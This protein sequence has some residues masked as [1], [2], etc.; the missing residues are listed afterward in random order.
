M[1]VHLVGDGSFESAA[2]SIHIGLINNM[3]DAALKATERQFL[4]L[5]NAAADGVVVNVSLYAL[6]EVPRSESAKGHIDRF[7]SGIDNLWDSRLDGLIVT[8]T[9]PRAENLRDEPYWG[10]LAKVVDWAAR[11]THSTV[12]S[13]L[14][15]HAAVLHMDNIPRI[16]SKH[17]H[18]G[19][20]ECEKLS[21]HPLIDGT[22][23][24]FKIPHSRWN[25]LSEEALTASG[26]EVLTRAE[27]VGV[28]TFIK[29]GKNL[30]VFFNGHPEYASNTLLLEYKRD[31]IRFLKSETDTYPLLPLN[32]FAPNIVATLTALEE[33]AKANPSEKWVAD[34]TAILEEIRIE[35]SWHATAT[36][37]YQNWLRFISVQKRQSESSFAPMESHDRKSQQD[38]PISS[39]AATTVADSRHALPSKL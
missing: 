12:W 33:Q 7:Y 14:A 16:R 9:E 23:P 27:N 8:G 10:S 3:P 19:V 17:K 22:P 20:I 4:S 37:I 29:E 25:G 13:C 28:D 15:A 26:Y 36:H 24:S 1:P 18:F 21:N 2:Q 5:L 34:L 30:L 6:P 39:L 11:H 31:V 35:S 38:S 32:Y